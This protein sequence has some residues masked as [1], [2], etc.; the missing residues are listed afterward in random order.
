MNTELV[1]RKLLPVSIQDVE[2]AVLRNH[3]QIHGLPSGNEFWANEIAL[4]NQ[5]LNFRP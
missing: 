3:I 5:L 4:V 1:W 2:S